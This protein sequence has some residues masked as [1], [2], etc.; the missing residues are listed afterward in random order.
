MFIFSYIDLGFLVEMTVGYVGVDLIVFCREVVMCVFFKN[1]K[2]GSV[3]LLFL[4]ECNG[5]FLD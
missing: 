1:E 4:D 3:Y 5:N 2:V